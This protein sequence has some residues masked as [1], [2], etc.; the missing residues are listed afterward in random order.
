MS[1]SEE[2]KSFPSGHV[3]ASMVTCLFISILPLINKE[4]EKYQIPLFYCFF[5]WSLL[6]AFSRMLVGAHFLSDV[7]MGGLIASTCM[8]INNEV[9]IVVNRK[10]EEKAKVVE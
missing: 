5:A 8:L 1:A 2:F 10:I 7:S 4:Y 9:L 6:V 3:G